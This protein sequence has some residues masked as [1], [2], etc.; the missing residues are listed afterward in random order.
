MINTI[1]G[2]ISFIFPI[3]LYLQLYKSRDLGFLILRMIWS[4]V[5]FV[6]L[7]IISIIIGVIIGFASGMI[8]PK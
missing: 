6:L 1:L 2:L 4:G 3:W 5:L 8:K 7:F